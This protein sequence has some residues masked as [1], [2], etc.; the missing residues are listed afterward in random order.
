[1]NTL[2]SYDWL[3]Q[4]VKLKETP[5]EFARRVSLSGPSVEKILALNS[6]LGDKIVVGRVL[7]LKKHPNADKLKLVA[8]DV[9]ANNHS[10]LQIVCGG[11]NLEQDQLVAVALV[12]AKVRWHGAGD[13]VTLEPTEIRGVKSLGMICSSNEIGLGE[14]FPAEERMI[15]DVG[16]E[17]GWNANS[18]FQIPNSKFTPP[19]L[20]TPLSDILGLKDDVAMDIE[21]TSNRPDCM[22]VVGLAREAAAILNRPFTWKPAKS[23]KLPKFQILNSKFQIQVKISAKKHCPRYLAAKIEGVKVGPSPWWLKRRLMSAGLRPINNI[24]DISNFVMLELGQPT[25]IFDAAKLVGGIEV[26]LARNNETIMAL[27]GKEYDLDDSILLIADKEKPIAVAGIMGGEH[28]GVTA[29]TKDVIIEAATFDPVTI[30]RGSRQLNLQSDAQL[31]FEKGLSSAAPPSALARTIELVLEIAGGKL[32]GGITDV[33]ETRYTP[34]KFST[35]TDEVDSLIGVKVPKT[36][37]LA[38]LRRLGF[39][40]SSQGKT[41]KAEVPWWRDHDIEYGRDLVEEIARLEGYA[42]IPGVIPFELAP[43]PMEAELKWEKTLRDTSKGAGLTEVYTYSFVSRDLLAKAEYDAKRMLRVQNP[44]SQ[45]FEFMRTSLLPSLLQVASENAE[46]YP[47]IRIF[48]VANV[49][50]PQDTEHGTR[51]TEQKA[52]G[53]QAWSNLPDEQLELGALF[54]GMAEPWRAAKGYV[55]HVLDEM[56]VRDAEWRRLSNDSFWHPGRSVQVYKEGKLLATLGEVSPKIAKNFKL[57]HVALIDMPLE[58][59]IPFAQ[60]AKRYA[61]LPAFPE[62]KRDL[63]VVVDAH[64]EFNDLAKA[65]KGIIKGS[66]VQV[67]VEWFDTYRGTNLPADKKSSAM[68]LTFSSNERTLTSAEVDSLLENILLDLKQ[69]FKAEMRG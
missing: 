48:E 18:K 60:T 41:I 66:A 24:V 12:G 1:M 52:R 63:A 23:I 28:T 53:T 8:V 38:R 54:I 56:G 50:Y 69:K 39:K 55:E 42:N 11:S 16:L 9:G 32:A 37:M 25:H 62:A 6:E 40:V 31:R 35:T 59:A 5:D 68:H 10:P 64:V 43:R 33:G 4:Y 45:D 51:N 14:I 49:Y 19:K 58:S 36:E 27:D 2:V 61:P 47:D 13:L 30:R 44:L 29:L 26:R 67:E 65:I 57:E 3:K 15:L 46:R 20:G 17:M 21:V 34:A 7:E 22:G